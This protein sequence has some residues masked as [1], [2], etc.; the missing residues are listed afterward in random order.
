MQEWKHFT[1]EARDF[2]FYLLDKDP[3]SRP[4]TQEALNHEWFQIKKM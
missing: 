1:S 2:C 4:T 3:A